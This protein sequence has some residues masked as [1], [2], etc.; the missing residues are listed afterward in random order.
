MSVVLDDYLIWEHGDIP[1]EGASAL[2]PLDKLEEVI[3]E[4]VFRA[5]VA[6]W[7][8]RIGVEPKE[9][10]LRA[11]KRKWASCSSKGRLTFDPE[12]LKQPA[13]FRAEVIVHELLHLRIPNHGPLF[14]AMVKAYL[15]KY[16]VNC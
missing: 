13:A 4:A 11:M 6:T 2:A 12:L 3:P 7:A 15:A 16:G 1:Y 8:R 14:K 10:H 5:E 9:I